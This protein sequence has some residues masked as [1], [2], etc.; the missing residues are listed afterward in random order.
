MD[1]NFCQVRLYGWEEIT[2]DADEEAGVCSLSRILRFEFLSCGL[3]FCL[4]R[5]TVNDLTYS[6]L[7]K[8][9]LRIRTDLVL[10]AFAIK[11]GVEV[12]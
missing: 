9:S 10:M 7:Y 8:L 4:L 3:L 6:W 11:G 2:I 12:D 1:H 5:K